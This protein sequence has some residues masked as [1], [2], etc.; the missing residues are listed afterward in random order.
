MTLR[1]VPAGFSLARGGHAGP[2]IEDGACL[3][4]LSAWLA[5]EPWSDRPKCVCP[6]LAMLGRT[7]NDNLTDEERNEYLLRFAIPLVGTRSTAEVEQQRGYIAADWAL[8][9]AVP[10]LLRELGKP[11]GADKLEALPKLID[12]E[13]VNSATGAIMELW[14]DIVSAWTM[15]ASRATTSYALVLTSLASIILGHVLFMTHLRSAATMSACE[16]LDRMIAVGEKD[17]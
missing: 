10:W 6:T 14:P 1:Q 13:T 12:T 3:L 2:E 5:G 8:R 16:L 9:C 11:A 7:L 4:E 17:A 15:W